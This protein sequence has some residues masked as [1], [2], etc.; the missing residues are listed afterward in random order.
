MVEHRCLQN[1]F[2]HLNLLDSH[3]Y[4][5]RSYNNDL[6]YT[7]WLKD[8][9]SLP[10]NSMNKNRLGKNHRI[11]H[12]Q[13]RIIFKKDR[14]YINVLKQKR[15]RKQMRTWKEQKTP[16]AKVRKLLSKTCMY[17]VK[18]SNNKQ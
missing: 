6:I 9:A 11:H 1:T 2:G 8:K 17:C 4:C 14:R 16:E 18:K 3:H 12:L 7:V 13:D 5:H 15:M 10:S